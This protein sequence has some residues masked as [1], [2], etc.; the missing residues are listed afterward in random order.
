LPVVYELLKG[1]GGKAE[2]ARTPEA[3]RNAWSL[4]LGCHP[5]NTRQEGEVITYLFPFVEIRLN[6][7]L[8]MSAAIQGQTLA[9]KNAKK[10]DGRTFPT[11]S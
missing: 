2:E 3:M 10:I 11:S 7:V 9:N 8:V 4:I 1:G 5:A 6:S